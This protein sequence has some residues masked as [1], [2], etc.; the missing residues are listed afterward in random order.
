MKELNRIVVGAA[1]LRIMESDKSQWC[2]ILESGK[3]DR[4]S[5]L[6]MHELSFDKKIYSW[7][8]LH[9]YS[10]NYIQRFP[11]NNKTISL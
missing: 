3:W 2:E 7:L 4:I 8:H 1:Q 10:S 5:A 11:N 9:Y 6:K